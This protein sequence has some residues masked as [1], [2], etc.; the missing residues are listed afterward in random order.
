MRPARM[1]HLGLVAALTLASP[2]A[3]PAPKS[4]SYE[5]KAGPGNVHWGYF[6]AAVKPALFVNPGD[7][8]VMED[9][10]RI[11][12][13]AVEQ[14]GVPAG[15]IPDH[16]RAIYREVKDRGPGSHIL[17]G[18]VYVNGAE[19]GDVLEVRVLD[20][21]LASSFAY[22]RHGPKMGAVPEEAPESFL[23][24][25]R[26]DQKHRTAEVA[27]GVVIPLT[28]PFFGTMGVAPEAAKGRITSVAPGVHAGNLD[29]KELGAGS[30][31]YLPV[32]VPG[33]LFSAGDGHAAQ[34]D[35]EVDLNAI[36]AALRGRFQFFVHKGMKLKWP[37]AET[38][39]HWIVMGLDA[40]L[41]EAMKIAVRET[42]DFIVERFP[43]LTR[44]E[45]YMIASVAVDYRV[46]Q[47]VD[48]VKGIHGMV[49][50]AIFTGK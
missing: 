28:R 13:A 8:V 34:G 30:I 50:K 17:V 9:V 2:L 29:N 10:V 31:L 7:I 45:A 46:T 24:V 12:P 44:P 19:P 11:D 48:Q 22:N 6:S 16:H 5:L 47:V 18:P 42:I 3:Q 39:T 37:R 15:E 4:A 21:Q 41:E 40:N 26:F 35:G 14:A 49:P 36:E 25:I 33:A 32:Y 1:A 38:P 27:S 23:R 20:V 43:R